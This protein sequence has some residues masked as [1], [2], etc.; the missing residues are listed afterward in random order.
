MIL[1]NTNETETD[2]QKLLM[3][4]IAGGRINN[5]L[6]IVPTNRKIRQLKKIIIDNSP[7]SSVTKIN[8]HTLGTLTNT[9][10]RNEIQFNDLTEAAAGV[11]IK[12]SAEKTELKYFKNYDKNMPPGTLSR[13]KNVI[14]RYKETGITSEILLN[15]TKNLSVAEKLKAEDIANIYEH[16]LDY[17]RLTNTY[18]LGDIY[19]GVLEF[20]E[21]LFEKHFRITFPE[22]QCTLILGFNEFTPLER[23]I[24]SLIGKIHNNSCYMEFDSYEYNPNIFSGLQQSVES[25][26]TLGFKRI[27]DLSEDNYAQ[28]VKHLRLFLFKNGK[29]ERKD[30]SDQMKIVRTFD[31]DREVEII[32]KEIKNLIIN[33][34]VDPGEICV[35]FNVIENY[36]QLIRFAFQ[37]YGIP[38]NLTDRIPLSDTYPVSAIINF[39]EIAQDDFY[40]KNIARAFQSGFIDML[41]I[42]IPNLISV[43]SKLKVVKGYYAWKNTLERAINNVAEEEDNYLE[44]DINRFKKALNDIE[45][46][47]KLLLPFKKKLS[48]DEFWSSLL[49]SINK[50]N[51]PQLL[52]DN[53]SEEDEKNIKAFSTFLDTTEEIFS[54]LKNEYSDDS[55]FGLDFFLD[56]IKTACRQGRFNTKEKTDYGV[57]VTTLNEIRGLKFQ[58]LFLGGMIDGDFPTRYKPEIFFAE[59]YAK[60]EKEHII[61]ERYLLYQTLLTWSKHL[62]ITIP[63]TDA[64]REN[65][66]STF[67]KDLLKIIK[68]KETTDKEYLQFIYSY[69]ELQK[70]SGRITKGEFEE[71]LLEKGK[72]NS[73]QIKNINRKIFVDESRLRPT[74]DANNYNGNLLDPLQTDENNNVSEDIIGEIKINLEE[75][76]EK[77]FSVSELE[78]YAKCPFK[79]FLERILKLN[80]EGEPTEE[81]EAIEL[82]SLLHSI[83]FEFYTKLRLKNKNLKNCSQKEFSEALDLIFSIASN[84]IQKSAFSSPLAFYDLEKLTGFGGNKEQSILYKFVNNERNNIDDFTPKFFEVSFGKSFR[85]QFDIEL[86]SQAPIEIDGIKIKGKIDRIELSDTEDKFNITDY[87]LGLSKSGKPSKSDFEEGL[88][89]QLPLYLMCAKALLKYKFSKDFEPEFIYLYSLKYKNSDFGKNKANIIWDKE[90]DINKNN[91]ILIE[92]ST[93]KIKEYV[94]NIGKGNFPLT[95]LKDREKKVCGY[96]DFKAVCRIEEQA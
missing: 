41:D 1:T 78:V 73:N 27:T 81:I 24:V 93:N 3:G 75:F 96:C 34:N 12:K 74:D 87:K 91:Q 64:G 52:I 53:P 60:K 77:E 30:F 8:L 83:L 6:L 18:E 54:L 40:Y 86:N 48:I 71:L 62:I 63:E 29:G 10:L 76:T 20:K 47:N 22:V 85:D 14:S 19:R 26:L 17:N 5:L 11:F 45:K 66:E 92:Q 89:L 4:T 68:C 55:K 33:K 7:N 88:S 21:T 56:Q 80:V 72:Y 15:E 9:L 38:F 44:S 94:E 67:I 84:Q 13:I 32:S 28:F 25:L 35:A 58:Y 65:S 31:R 36:S 23:N 37:Q 51:I 49:T 2:I 59:C 61:D 42:D 39:L 57:L 95:Q 70:L 43:G 79:Y 90:L 50:L 69:E 46:L 82:G 16:Y